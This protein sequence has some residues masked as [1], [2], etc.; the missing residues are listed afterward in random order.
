[1]LHGYMNYNLDRFSDMEGQ[2]ESLSAVESFASLWDS[3]NADRGFSWESNP[4]AWVL[5]FGVVATR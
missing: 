3:I 2:S 1:M 5:E 4:W